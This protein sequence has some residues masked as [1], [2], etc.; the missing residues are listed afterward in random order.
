[1]SSRIRYIMQYGGDYYAGHNVR[2]VLAYK[3]VGPLKCK[4]DFIKLAADLKAKIWIFR[5]PR[6]VKFARSRYKK[7]CRTWNLNP[8]LPK[9][10]PI[11][12]VVNTVVQY[13][14]VLHAA[15]GAHNGENPVNRPTRPAVRRARIL[16]ER[17]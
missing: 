9:A 7:I 10:P 13:A 4:E 17:I 11:A 16:R 15:Q 12:H 14:A 8:R 6:F 5:E 3:T 1:M 2:R